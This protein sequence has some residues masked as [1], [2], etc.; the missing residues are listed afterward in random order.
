MSLQSWLGSPV[1][2]LMEDLVSSVRGFQGFTLHVDVQLTGRE[3]MSTGSCGTFLWA[4]PR[5]GIYLFPSRS[6]S[7]DSKNRT[8]HTMPHNT[9][10]KLF[11]PCF[12]YLHYPFPILFFL[13]PKFSSRSSLYVSAILIYLPCN[14]CFS[15]PH[16]PE[17][18]QWSTNCKNPVFS[19]PIWFIF[20]LPFPFHPFLQSVYNLELDYV[21]SLLV[22][23]LSCWLCFC[24]LWSS[25]HVSSSYFAKIIISF[26]CLQISEGISL[27]RW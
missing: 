25:P 16:S 1:P 3:R 26:H 14:L 12:A 21:S 13:L 11:L 6:I 5:S 7:S 17:S 8:K 15:L 2:S 27:I 22:G 23:L 19:I 20:S 4:R 10:T 24:S 9:H 18:N